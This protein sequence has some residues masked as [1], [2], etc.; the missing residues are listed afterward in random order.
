MCKRTQ[1]YM[2]EEFYKKPELKDNELD[3]EEIEE[4]KEIVD[5]FPWINKNELSVRDKSFLL[6]AYTETINML[7][8]VDRF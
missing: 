6:K 8:I 5:Y 7:A 4:L 1:T 3:K 2:R